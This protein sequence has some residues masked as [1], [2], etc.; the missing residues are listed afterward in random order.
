MQPCDV[1]VVVV[2][3]VVS[4]VCCV[5][6]LLATLVPGNKRGRGA[7]C[8][9]FVYVPMSRANTSVADKITALKER[10]ILD[11]FAECT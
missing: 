8:E 2:V 7:T 11:R 10:S 3:V 5:V 4:D 6:L 1:L 9:A